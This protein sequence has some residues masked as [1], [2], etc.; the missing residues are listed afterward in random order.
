MSDGSTK[1]IWAK[2][3][4]ARDTNRAAQVLW[5]LRLDL[6]YLHQDACHRD[7][8]NL[9]DK[10]VA[11][12]KKLTSI[13]RRCRTP[14]SALKLALKSRWLVELTDCRAKLAAKE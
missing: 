10:T 2:I 3:E 6:F 13:V 7:D 1:E 11:Q 5:R 9:E 14:E 8:W 4:S 12:R